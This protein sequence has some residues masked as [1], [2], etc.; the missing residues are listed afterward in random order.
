MDRIE[1]I[2]RRTPEPVAPVP[3]MRRLTRKEREQRERERRRAAGH[4]V[5]A[6]DGEEPGDDGQPH[7]DVLA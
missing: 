4:A 2:T 1:P 5:P 6:G 7:V 3:P